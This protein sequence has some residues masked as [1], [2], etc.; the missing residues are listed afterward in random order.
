MQ[1][2][3]MP[4]TDSRYEELEGLL[5]TYYLTLLPLRDGSEEDRVFF[6]QACETLKGFAERHDLQMPEDAVQQP[7]SRESW[8]QP[9]VLTS[10]FSILDLLNGFW[11]D[12]GLCSQ[13]GSEDS[14]AARRLASLLLGLLHRRDF[15][16]AGFAAGVPVSVEERL[17]QYYVE[18]RGGI[19]A[20]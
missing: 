12:F 6:E 5:G 4:N 15:I 19:F 18:R 14:T 11:R 1:T 20:S 2:G 13:E 8:A 9:K 16:V 10:A 3:P 17:P 7:R